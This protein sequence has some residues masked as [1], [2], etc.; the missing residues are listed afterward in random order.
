MK[1][2]IREQLWERIQR[3]SEPDS[4][5]LKRALKLAEDTHAGA[6]RKPTVQQPDCRDPYIVHPM[7]VALILIDEVDLSDSDAVAAGLLHDTIEDSAGAV[8]RSTIL[9][10]FGQSVADIVCALS[11][12]EYAPGV[13]RHEQLA[14]YHQK[15]MIAPV[16]TRMV[17]LADRLDNIREALLTSERPFQHR[18]LAETRTTYLPLAQITSDYFYKSI[19]DICDRLE[20][21]LESSP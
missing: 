9:E 12:P 16:K 6:Y 14:D 18:Y 4:S 21:L 11:K 7:R 20:A 17:K 1:E 8:T 19:S 10:K 15:L 2:R 3:Y 13:A 5:L